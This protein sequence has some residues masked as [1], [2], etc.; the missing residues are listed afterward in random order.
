MPTSSR[1]LCA[2]LTAAAVLV[3]T[4]GCTGG[5]GGTTAPS[6]TARA[7]APSVTALA[8]AWT[9]TPSASLWSPGVASSSPPAW[10]KPT[11][12]VIPQTRSLTS[13]A[14][15]TGRRQWTLAL[16][17]DVCALATAPNTSGIA[18]VLLGKDTG[19]VDDESCAYAAAVD[20][21]TGRLL[22]TT[23]I[24]GLSEYGFLEAAV[25]PKAVVVTNPCDTALSLSIDDGARLTRLAPHGQGDGCLDSFASDGTTI[26]DGVK[27]TAHDAFVGYAADSGR[28]RW[29]VPLARALPDEAANPDVRRVL[30]SN[31]VVLD[32]TVNG[33]RFLR[34]LNPTARTQR[35][36]GRWS[37]RATAPLL[38]VA[39]GTRVA[40]QYSGS[41]ELFV[42]DATTGGEVR[43]TVLGDGEFAIGVRGHEVLTERVGAGTPAGRAVVG[44]VGVGSGRRQVLGTITATTAGRPLAVAGS[45][46]VLG[47][48]SSLTALRLPSTGPVP[49]PSPA[50]VTWARG[51]VRPSTAVDL[52]TGITASTKKVLRFADPALP[53][54]ANCRW[55]ESVR[56]GQIVQL[57]VTV[58]AEPPSGSQTALAQAQTTVRRLSRPDDVNHLPASTAVTGLGDQAFV[59]SRS[60][61]ISLARLVAR[62]ANVV[63][64]IDV[65]ADG[66]GAAVSPTV[67]QHGA[68]AAAVDVI[69]TL[70]RRR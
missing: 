15:T 8:A 35:P 42:Y 41:P 25:G 40:V 44:A 11:S 58:T 59:V 14:A 18:A 37:D 64:F 49:G 60:G 48:L 32:A 1:S 27:H 24:Q 62:R 3:L 68:R 26:V 38:A 67:L 6:A 66:T 36:F 29:T 50:G 61:S 31:P 9:A 52:C 10:S 5:G 57:S 45:T 70:D 54:P 22:W 69:A 30:S 43:H 28:R 4:A 56:G 23:K 33:H 7:K 21:H 39:T 12:V 20:L 65:T 53:A 16:P 47:D 46:L 17:Q 13:Y 51:D 19:S 55:V 2:A 34:T 63:V